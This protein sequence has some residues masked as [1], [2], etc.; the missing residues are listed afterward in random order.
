MLTN[1]EKIQDFLKIIWFSFSIIFNFLLLFCFFSEIENNMHSGSYSFF[2]SLFFNRDFN[3]KVKAFFWL[4]TEAFLLIELFYLGNET[5]IH[6][7]IVVMILWLSD[8]H[9]VR[10]GN[11][12][13]WSNLIQSLTVFEKRP[14][15]DRDW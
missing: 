10:D 8:I 11:S 12:P 5:L 15:Q 6:L 1:F 7:Y 13:I 9:V 4:F 2:D 3:D 14:D